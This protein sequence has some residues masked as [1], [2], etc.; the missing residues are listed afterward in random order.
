VS[1]YPDTTLRIHY[2]ELTLLY[3]QKSADFTI[4]KAQLL[5]KIQDKKQGLPQT[6]YQLNKL[7]ESVNELSDKPA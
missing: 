2:L 3:L 4:K 7:E 5:A 6:D 1:V